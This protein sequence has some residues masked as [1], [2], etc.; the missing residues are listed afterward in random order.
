LVI[1]P[2]TYIPENNKCNELLKE[3]KDNNISIAIVIDEYGGTSGIVTLEDLA[4]VLFGDFEEIPITDKI[5]IQALNKVSWRVNASESIKT[6][7]E[8]LT[9]KF[10][11]GNYETIAGLLITRLGHIPKEGEQLILNEFRILVTKSEKNR[12]VEVRIIRR[13]DS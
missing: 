10:P 9:A 2:V 11:E 1:K 7:N 12:I 5:S 4:E 3:F 6:I 8:Q 13:E